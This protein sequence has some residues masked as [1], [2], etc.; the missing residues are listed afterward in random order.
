VAIP[1]VMPTIRESTDVPVW[2]TG[3]ITTSDQAT[4]VLAAGADV[5][6]SAELELWREFRDA[7]IGD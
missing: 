1:Q 5:I 4:A 6:S 7:R 2:G 3:F